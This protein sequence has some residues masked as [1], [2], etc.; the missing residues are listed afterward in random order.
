MFCAA[1]KKFCSLSTKHLKEIIEKEV[2]HAYSIRHVERIM[3][4]LG[5]S[6]VKPR[7][8]HIKHDQK[9]VDEFRA[10]FKK[11]FNRSIWVLPSSHLM[12]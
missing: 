3:H 6:Q 5:F 7:S 2:G 8:Q 9:K 10:M 12:K 1:N 11:N 4:K